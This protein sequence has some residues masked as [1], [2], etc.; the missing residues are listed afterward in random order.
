MSPDTDTF[1]AVASYGKVWIGDIGL[2]I[3]KVSEFQTNT[4]NCK[5][6]CSSYKNAGNQFYFGSKLQESLLVHQWKFAVGFGVAASGIKQTAT[7]NEF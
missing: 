3:H 4:Y 1:H 2:S 6:L 7:V 5:N